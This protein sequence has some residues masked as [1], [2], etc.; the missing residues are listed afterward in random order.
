MKRSFSVLIAVLFMSGSVFSQKFGYFNSLEILSMVPEIKAA[1]SDLAAFTKVLQKEGEAKYADLQAKAQ[2]LEDRNAKGTISPKQYQE[3]GAVLEAAGQD[4]QKLQQ[5]MEKKIADKRQ[6]LYKP[7]LDKVNE[8]IAEVA[9]ENGYQ[10][11]FDSSTGVL[12]HADET[13]DVTKLVKAKLN[14]TE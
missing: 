10:L 3:E 12:L 11:I 14:I 6:T 7:I 8:K 2:S 9:K 13:L 5:E 1:D 4:L